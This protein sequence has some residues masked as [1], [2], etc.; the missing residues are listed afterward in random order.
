MTGT[1]L[2]V[3]SVLV[4]GS[5][6]LAFGNRLPE[7]VRGTV[8]AALGL[9]T[10][11]IGVRL[12]L[13]SEEP[14]I[15][16]G[17][18]ALGGLLGEWWQLE[19]KLKSLGAGLEARAFDRICVGHVKPGGGTDRSQRGKPGGSRLGAGAVVRGG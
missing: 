15:A 1:V 2:N 12:F 14:I 17:S 10:L 7:R 16:I 6:G 19:D 11:A 8:T 13:Q 9:F 3:A 18:L 5:L 4:G